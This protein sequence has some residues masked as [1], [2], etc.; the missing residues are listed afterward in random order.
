[1]LPIIL[2]TGALNCIRKKKR[3]KGRLSYLPPKDSKK[4][5]E[6]VPMDPELL[7]D[8]SGN[9]DDDPESSLFTLNGLGNVE[10]DSGSDCHNGSGSSTSLSQN[11]SEESGHNMED[12]GAASGVL[13]DQSFRQNSKSHVVHGPP[14]DLL[15]PLSEKVPET[16]LTI[17][18]NFLGICPLMISHIGR[19]SIGDP[20]FHMGSGKMRLLWID[21]SISRFGSLKV[22]TDSETG[23]HIDRPEV[24][25]VDALT[26]RIEPLEADEKG[27]MTVDGERVKEYGPIQAQVHPHL[28]RIMT[29][30]RWEDS[31]LGQRAT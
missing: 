6:A 24:K 21:G 20:N 1:V 16:W 8:R 5:P 31:T 12:S 11:S 27:I 7:L 19:T 13:P 25:L 22:F 26:F 2:Y 3:Y 15:V 30:R 23:K 10:E 4:E 17:E 29:R 18:Q 14:T 9:S 28:A